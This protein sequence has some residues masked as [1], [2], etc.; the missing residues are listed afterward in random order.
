MRP[1]VELNQ[2]LGLKSANLM[3]AKERKNVMVWLLEQI[4]RFALGL[5]INRSTRRIHQAANAIALKHYSV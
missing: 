1:F 2:A 5:F 3:R 4:V